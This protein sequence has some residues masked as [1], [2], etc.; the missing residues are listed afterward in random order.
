MVVLYKE[1]G[2]IR[3]SQKSCH[4]TVSLLQ[5]HLQG[6]S[7][8]QTQT[9]LKAPVPLQRQLVVSVNSHAGSDDTQVCMYVFVC[10]SE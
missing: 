4:H 1:N 8:T 5:T 9:H 2:E 10:V 7:F 3:T 6:Q